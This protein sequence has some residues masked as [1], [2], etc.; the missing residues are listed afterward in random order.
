MPPERQRPH[1]L[2]KVRNA[3]EIS[4]RDVRSFLRNPF[5][6]PGPGKLTLVHDAGISLTNKDR[7]ARSSD[8]PPHI[9]AAIQTPVRRPEISPKD[10]SETVLAPTKE[11]ADA[12]NAGKD[13]P[14]GVAKILIDAAK[15]HPVITVVAATPVLAGAVYTIPQVHRPVNSE[16][17]GWWNSIAEGVKSK[18]DSFTNKQSSIFQA[19]P[20]R[21]PDTSSISPDPSRLLEIRPYIQQVKLPGKEEVRLIPF[22][23]L[24]TFRLEY[25]PPITEKIKVF[26]PEYPDGT[27]IET[28]TSRIPNIYMQ[29]YVLAKE[30][31]LDGS[32]FIAVG[33]PKDENQLF[34]SENLDKPDTT[35]VDD[36]IDG[37][38]GVIVWLKIPNLIDY[39]RPLGPQMGWSLPDTSGIKS[40]LNDTTDPNEIFRYI[41]IGDAVYAGGYNPPYTDDK[42]LDTLQQNYQQKKGKI[43][44]EEA[45]Q[46]Y[47]ALGNKNSTTVRKMLEDARKGN[48]SLREQLETRRYTINADYLKFVVNN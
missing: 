10:R 11:E 43:P 12:A 40:V 24:F 16:V 19:P 7:S 29:G 21:N 45:K 32:V 30:Q 1:T 42:G 2:G 18:Y 4:N 25:E 28:T 13:A 41:K 22:P 17:A 27:M 20:G 44:Y 3:N 31:D 33:I 5:A 23:S 37:I 39:Q 14:R 26:T 8:V 47:L 9:F 6:K 48:V 34:S 36:R 35:Q 38:T 46:Q 15:N